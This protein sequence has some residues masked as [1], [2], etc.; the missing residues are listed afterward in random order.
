MDIWIFRQ[1]MILLLP[2]KNKKLLIKIVSQRPNK[3]CKSALGESYI[4]YVP[5]IVTTGLCNN[6]QYIR[7]AIIKK[8]PPDKKNELHFFICHLK[9]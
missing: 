3:S 8:K 2:I 1:D 9:T 4:S 7:M 6:V 5:T